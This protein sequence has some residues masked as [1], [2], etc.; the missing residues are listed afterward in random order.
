MRVIASLALVPLLLS[1]PARA[2]DLMDLLQQGPVVAVRNDAKGKFDRATAVVDVH[3]PPS[4]VWDVVSNF[5]NYRYFMPKVARSE[6]RMTGPNQCDVSYEIEVPVLANAK[7]VF[8]YTLDPAAMTA[9][10]QWIKGDIQGSF[11]D[12]KLVPSKDGTLVYFTTASRNYS[13]LAQRFEDDQQ[14]ITIGVNVSAA[15]ATVRAI[16]KRSEMLAGSAAA[17]P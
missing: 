2:Q 1:L 16:K 13:S 3:A 14:T 17:K 11:C 4:S 12:W 6:Q 7:Y 10:G 9:H 15:L 8:H 5:S